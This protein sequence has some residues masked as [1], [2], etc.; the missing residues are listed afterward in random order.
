[1]PILASKSF[2]HLPW[3]RWS[4]EQWERLGAKKVV[5]ASKTHQ[6]HP[7]QYC[8]IYVRLNPYEAYFLRVLVTTAVL[9]R[10]TRLG[11]EME[12]ENETARRRQGGYDFLITPLSKEQ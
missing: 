6:F 2:P 11:I 3:G 12:F 7:F 8:R 1:M 10:T 9:C 4:W 5:Q